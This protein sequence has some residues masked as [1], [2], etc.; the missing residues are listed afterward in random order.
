[1]PGF[2][3]PGDGWSNITQVLYKR[4]GNTC[5]LEWLVQLL[6]YTRSKPYDQRQIRCRFTFSLHSNAKLTMAENQLPLCA[7]VSTL[8][9]IMCDWYQNFY[10]WSSCS[11]PGVHFFKTSMDGSKDR[12]CIYGPHER[13]IVMPDAC[14]LC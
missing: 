2:A 3:T 14:P 9:V 12:R 7:P 5:G 4:P 8:T 6:R 10:I 13:Y 1:M 11:D